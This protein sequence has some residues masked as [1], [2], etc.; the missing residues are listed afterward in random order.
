VYAEAIGTILILDLRS[1]IKKLKYNKLKEQ[2][3]YI[4]MPK[5]KKGN[6]NT[7]RTA[8]K[9]LPIEYANKAL[10]QEYGII[11]EVLGNC[12][13]KVNTIINESKVASLCGSIKRTG[14]VRIGDTILME[15]LTE[16]TNGK[17][18]IIFKYTPDQKKILENEGHLV[19]IIIPKFNEI[20]SD[21]DSSDDAFGFENDEDTKKNE[22][23][24]EVINDNFIDDI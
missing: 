7:R 24:V 19:K 9:K 11:A 21:D 18:Q 16:N 8:P 14:K 2:I 13:F 20:E 23:V 6:N 1:N 4:L 22:K 10:A 12:H 5:H 17:Y 3:L 15:P